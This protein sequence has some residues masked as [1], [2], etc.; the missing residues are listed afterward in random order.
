MRGR[1]ANGFA[2][3]CELEVVDLAR[4]VLEGTGDET[5][6]ALF[7]GWARLDGED[8][9][10]AF[11]SHLGHVEVDAAANVSA[12]VFDPI[13]TA[14]QFYFAAVVT[15]GIQRQTEE[16]PAI[17]GLTAIRFGLLFRM[18]ND[19]LPDLNPID[20][21]R[22]VVGKVN[23]SV[24]NKARVSSGNTFP[25]AITRK[26]CVPYFIGNLTEAFN[27][28]FK[29]RLFIFAWWLVIADGKLCQLAK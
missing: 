7:K 25:T 16:L 9:R 19:A 13:E 6:F 15:F 1:N 4:G 3:A 29:R 22:S 18:R 17:C 26:L 2:L 5:A 28:L 27:G 14:E 20:G 21:L 11:G 23:L 8:F 24:G 12:V 10:H